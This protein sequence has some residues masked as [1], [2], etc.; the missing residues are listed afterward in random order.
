MSG[1]E[2]GSKRRPRAGL[3]R[4]DKGLLTKL[5]LAAAI[6]NRVVADITE[7]ALT[8]WMANFADRHDD[9]TKLLVMWEPQEATNRS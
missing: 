5:K 1:N 7:E 2:Q 8:T 9:A 4:V 6:E 3:L